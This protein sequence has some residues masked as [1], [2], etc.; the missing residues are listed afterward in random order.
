MPAG[1]IKRCAQNR[2]YCNHIYPRS[3]KSPAL[4]LSFL[5]MRCNVSIVIFWL[6]CSIRLIV[7][8]LTPTFRANAVWVILPRLARILSAKAF[9]KL[10]TYG[11]VTLIVMHICINTKWIMNP[12]KMTA[13]SIANTY[14]AYCN[15]A[16]TRSSKSPALHLRFLQ[17]RCNVSIVIFWQPCSIRLMVAWLTPTF[18]ANAVW[19]IL[20]RLVR[21]FLARAFR[22]SVTY[23]KMALIV[24]HLYINE[25]RIV[26]TDEDGK[27]RR[28]L[29]A[30]APSVSS[31][32]TSPVN[33]GL[34]HM[35]FC[36]D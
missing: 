14:R 34:S 12:M 22:I 23:Q 13:N 3:S 9:R 5:Q 19:V 24:M 18:R 4:H 27:R 26:N 6:P 35:K 25:R 1:P 8:W 30:V 11:K 2:A 29:A 17:T 15:R 10:V 36:A 20:P 21:I 32:D 33:A 31:A 7:A 28:R 16:F